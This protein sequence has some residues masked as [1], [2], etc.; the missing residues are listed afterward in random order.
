M[1]IPKKRN[2][3]KEYKNSFNKF[4]DVLK[5]KDLTSLASDSTN[6]DHSYRGKPPLNYQQLIDGNL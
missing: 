6:I 3:S 1:K 4:Q 2:L 5:N